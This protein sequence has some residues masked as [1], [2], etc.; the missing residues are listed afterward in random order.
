MLCTGMDRL[1]L[2]GVVSLAAC[3]ASQSD[4]PAPPPSTYAIDIGHFDGLGPAEFTNESLAFSPRTE[5]VS[6][7]VSSED[8]TLRKVYNRISCQDSP[9]QDDEMAIAFFQNMASELPAPATPPV[10]LESISLVL[11][12]TARGPRSAGLCFAYRTSDGK[13]HGRFSP[14]PVTHDVAAKTSRVTLEVHADHVDVVGI[15]VSDGP[16]SSLS[17]VAIPDRP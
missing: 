6:R 17:F 10:R 4:P 15:P 12:D 5:A 1:T 2:F 13:W 8:D 7:I 9:T 11:P 14:V 3:T 16:V